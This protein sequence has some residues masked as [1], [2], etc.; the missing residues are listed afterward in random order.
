VQQTLSQET[1]IEENPTLEN[2]MA[3]QGHE[4]TFEPDAEA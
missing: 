4:A 3:G 1:K 2:E